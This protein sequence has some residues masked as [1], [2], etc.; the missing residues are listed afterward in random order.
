MAKPEPISDALK[1]VPL[2]AIPVKQV[3]T[4]FLFILIIFYKVRDFCIKFF[5]KVRDFC[6]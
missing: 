4:Y 1:S 6:M 5:Y 2:N 3:C